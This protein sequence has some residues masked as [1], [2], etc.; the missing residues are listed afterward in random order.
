MLAPVGNRMSRWRSPSDTVPFILVGAVEDLDVPGGRLCLAGRVARVPSYVDLARAREGARV[1][2]TGMLERS[3]GQA[4]IVGLIPV[5]RVVLCETRPGPSERS[6]LVPL[7]VRLLMERESEIEVLDCHLLPARHRYALR[8]AIPGEPGKE[9]L[10]PRSVLDRADADPASRH[11]V[12]A[13]LSAAARA[14]R[15]CPAPR[16]GGLP[17]GVARQVGAA[18][19]G[20]DRRCERCEGTLTLD[21]AV[22][23]EH[24]SSRHLTCSSP[25]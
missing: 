14:L 2:V 18:R 24:G 10:L 17:A 20:E 25:A 1:L 5:G 23:V 3:T 8:L 16:D 4:S 13:M 22:V 7:I 11:E 6:T 9:V 15:A 12:G 19:R 21:D